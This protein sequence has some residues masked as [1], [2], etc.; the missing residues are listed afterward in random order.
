MYTYKVFFQDYRKSIYLK[1]KLDTRFRHFVKADE[2][3]VLEYTK[4]V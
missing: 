2:Y 4:A 1:M 3:R